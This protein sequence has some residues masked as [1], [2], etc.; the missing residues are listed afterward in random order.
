LYLR[1][2]FGRR[3]YRNKARNGQLSWTHL[4]CDSIVCYP[5]TVRLMIFVGITLTSVVVV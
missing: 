3:T 1:I 5:I 2:R 4:L